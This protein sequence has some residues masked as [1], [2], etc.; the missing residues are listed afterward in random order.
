MT[1][2]VVVLVPSFDAG[3]H[4]LPAV[5]SA[6]DQTWH[7]L[8]VLVI[9]DG[10]TDGS[11]DGLETIDDPRLAILR[12]EHR[13]RAAALNA[14]L[15]WA[16]RRGAEYVVIQDAD[17]RSRPTRVAKLVRAL[18]AEPE[19]AACLS[20]H[21]LLVHGRR[22]APIAGGLDPDEVRASIDAF[23]MP[24]HDPTAA[25]R[26]SA[27]EHCR[28]SEDLRLGAGLDHLL[29]L[30]ERRPMRVLG[31]CLYDYRLH[32]AQATG[33][34]PGRRIPWVLD[35][36]TRAA[37]RRGLDEPAIEALRARF[38]RDLARA[39]H[40]GARIGVQAV[41]AVQACRRRG[42]TARAVRTAAEVLALRPL[43][44]FTWRAVLHAVRPGRRAA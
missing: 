6:L 27:L 5:R 26:T 3:P 42:D 33:G 15:A 7:D 4:L 20:G 10:G 39:T 13:G 23:R 32:D 25:F 36:V 37:R 2:R 18:D 29:R 35:V 28:W 14:G 30:G 31:A 9:D 1:S 17:D 34:D 41:T 19:L 40:P 11:V 21:A 22:F 12:R 24:A 44:P 8:T 43:D 38:A 16:R